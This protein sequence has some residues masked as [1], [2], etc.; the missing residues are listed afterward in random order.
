MPAWYFAHAQDDLNLPIL[1]MFE[2]TF[3]L[4]AA[5]IQTTSPYQIG[6]VLSYCSRYTCTQ[7]ILHNNADIY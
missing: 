3:L 2:G 7:V 5:H 1:H 4:D 6:L